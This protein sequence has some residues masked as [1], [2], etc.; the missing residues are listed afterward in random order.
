M[1]ARAAEYGRLH[2]IDALLQRGASINYQ[3][4]V[5]GSTAV[6]RAAG[7]GQIAAVRMLCER[8]AKLKLKV[9]T[10]TCVRMWECVH[11]CVCAH[12]GVCACVGVCMYGC[13]PRILP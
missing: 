13:V 10:P 7:R 3:S 6:M 12:V 11:V 5:D 1:L 2:V 4:N 9:G 8:G